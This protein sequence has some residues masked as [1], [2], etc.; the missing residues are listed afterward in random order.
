MD[1][2]ST[3]SAMET[4]EP[5]ETVGGRVRVIIRRKGFRMGWV[6]DQLGIAPSYLS[7][8]LSGDRRMTVEWAQRLADVLGVPL[9][10]VTG[11]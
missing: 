11:G 7:R 1:N 8:L 6:A 3:Y 10:E 2:V 5:V 4:R 9:S